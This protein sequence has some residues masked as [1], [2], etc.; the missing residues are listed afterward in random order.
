MNYKLSELA[1]G[2]QLRNMWLEEALCELCEAHGDMHVFLG[3]THMLIPGEIWTFCNL[4][5]NHSLYFWPKR[6]S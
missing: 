4:N 1:S 5:T 2:F 6:L 3:P